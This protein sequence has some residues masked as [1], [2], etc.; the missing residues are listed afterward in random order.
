ML[1]LAHNVLI[2][3]AGMKS[4]RAIQSPDPQDDKQWLTF[5]L[6]YSLFDLVCF[7]ADLFLWVIPFYGGVKCVILIFL[8]PLN[9]ALMV[10]PVLEPLL[11]RGDEVSR[12]YEPLLKQHLDKL[13]EHD[14]FKKMR[15]QAESLSKKAN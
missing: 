9:G 11:L 4:F 14:V 12:K 3:Y 15:Q 13:K 8:G 1:P 2:C 7:V 6:I 5:W 10:Y